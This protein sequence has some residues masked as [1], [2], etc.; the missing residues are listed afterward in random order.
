MNA[1]IKKCH[2][3]RSVTSLFL[4]EINSIAVLFDKYPLEKKDAYGYFLNQQYFLIRHSTRLL[5][6]SA[7]IIDTEEAK[8]FR[9]WAKHLQEEIDHDLSILNDMRSIGYD[10]NKKCEPTIRALS[11][12]L[13]EDIRRH[14]QDALLGYALML[15]GLSMKRCAIMADRI[16]KTYG[17]G[18][19]Y[20][21][22]HAAAD[23][24]HFPQGMAR[25]DEFPTHRKQTIIDNLHMSAHLYRNFLKEI[26]HQQTQ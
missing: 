12:A 17:K 26:S 6:L 10:F 3:E 11:L 9:W 5:A 18:F 4:N 25:I 15:E 8:E 24:K 7:S 21:K 19:S 13:F 2:T 20:F 22:L 1:K 14:G 16:N 23:E